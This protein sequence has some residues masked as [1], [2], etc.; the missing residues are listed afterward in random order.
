MVHGK[1]QVQ[2]THS[3][4]MKNPCTEHKWTREG[5]GLEEESK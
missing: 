1:W 4:S 3:E 2:G 5:R